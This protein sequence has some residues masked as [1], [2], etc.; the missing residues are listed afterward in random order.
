ML[1]HA[2]LGQVL[3]LE[4]IYGLYKNLSKN[5]LFIPFLDID[6]L[7]ENLINKISLVIINLFISVII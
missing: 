6:F 3:V 2:W 5:L 4:T 7:H 1:A